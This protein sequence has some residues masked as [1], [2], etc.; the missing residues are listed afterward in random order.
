MISLRPYQQEA[1]DA[2][3]SYL[4]KGNGLLVLPTGSG[5]SVVQAEFLR[6][7]LA[8]FPSERFLLVSHVRELLVQNAEKITALWPEAPVGLYSAGLKRRDIA[9]ITVAGI[10]SVY[11]RADEFGDVGV[12]IID[13]CH[14]VPKS[15][16]GMYRT[17]LGDLQQVNPSLKI[18]GMSATHYRLNSGYLHQGDGAMFSGV[19]YE[20][21]VNQLIKDGHL[22]NLKSKMGVTRIDTSRI[23]LRA[24]E[25]VDHEL[26]EAMDTDDLVHRAVGEIAQW[27]E[28][29]K[30][31]LVFCCGVQHAQ[32]VAAELKANGID[33]GCVWGEMED[34]ERDR[35]LSDF[36]SGTLRA[37]TNC[38]VLTVGFDAP[39][40]DAIVLLRP[41]MSPGLY[42][43][44]VGR[45]F[46][47]ADGKEDCL[48]LDFGGNI[49]RHGPVDQVVVRGKGE[50]A[51]PA[52][53][54]ECPNCHTVIGIALL[55]C[56]ECGYEYPKPA[57]V[58]PVPRHDVRPAD[59]DIL[60]GTDRKSIF[61][62]EIDHV[63]YRKWDSK[64]GKPP[65]LRV[66]HWE[67]FT[68]YSQWVSLEA[69]GGARW[70]AEQ[71]WKRRS[72]LPSPSTVDEALALCKQLKVPRQ[73]TVDASGEY[74]RIIGYS[75]LHQPEDTEVPF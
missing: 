15:G 38:N 14:L 65:T 67:G 47:K 54:K 6:R 53:F 16:Q 63:T 51:A 74:T 19:A 29:R 24:G 56:P 75:D 13:E 34:D 1:V 45:G 7:A 2:L 3:Y 21:G 36:R 41:T 18:V 4:G 37:V 72:D 43:Q 20:V 48:I 35:V 17:L 73:I 66:D 60:S 40:I 5:K 55:A 25:F 64:K 31:I 44:M 42:V 10:Q 69:S 50:R 33:T 39:N 68:H 30:K 61:H 23:H 28:F 52:P 58:P 27:C 8:D 9:P 22:C 49:L 57:G 59:L 12:V 11:Q 26:N 70:H 62:A 71:W 32:H 46:R